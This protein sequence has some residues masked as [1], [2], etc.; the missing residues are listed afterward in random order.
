MASALAIVDG[1]KYVK[2]RI[3]IQGIV[4]ERRVLEPLFQLGAWPVDHSSGYY[5]VAGQRDPVRI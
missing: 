5:L 3:R 1:S 2:P 4:A